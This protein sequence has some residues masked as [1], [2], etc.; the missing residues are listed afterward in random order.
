MNK[1]NDIKEFVRLS[2]GILYTKEFRKLKI[3]KYYINKLI[4]DGIIERYKPGVYLRNGV[5]GDEYYILQNRGPAIVYSL[6]TAL[7]LHNIIEAEPTNI[8][9]TVYTGYNTSHLPKNIKRHFIKERNYYLGITK[10]KTQNGFKVKLYDLE[11]TACDLIKAR[12]TGLNQ[13]QINEFLNMIFLEETFDMVKLIKY[14]EKLQ[15]ESKVRNT[16]ELFS[17]NNL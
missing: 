2:N 15:C 12:N 13:E 5:V 6:S 17:S 9:I 7:Y 1:Y 8:D 10:V 14:A 11:R 4:I 3:G 16:I